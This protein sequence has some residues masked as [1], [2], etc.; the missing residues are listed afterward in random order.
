MIRWLVGSLLLQSVAIADGAF[1]DSMQILLPLDRPHEIILATNFGLVISHDDGTR[2]R[3]ICEEAIGPLA[4]L[5]QVGPPPEDTLLAPAASGLHLSRNDA[6][7][8]SPAQGGLAGAQ[9]IDAFPDATDAKHLFALGILR[10]D[11]G[12]A[13]IRLFESHDAGLTFEAPL[14]SAPVGSFF[15]GVE[16]AR[17]DPKIVYLTRYAFLPTEDPRTYL[18]RSDDSGAHFESFDET[19]AVG[20]RSLRIAAIDPEDAK[21]IYLRVVGPTGQD[22]FALSRDGGKTV[23]ATLTLPGLMSAF[24]RRSDKALLVGSRQGGGFISTD[25]GK[26]FLPW[27]GAPHL[28]ALGERNGL[29]YAAA[30]N[31]A[32]GFSVGVSSDGG[33]HFIPKLR[34]HEIQGPLDCVKNTCAA[35]WQK[36]AALFGIDTGSDAGQS[37]PPSPGCGCSLGQHGRPPLWC[38]LLG[39]LLLI[40]RPISR[41]GCDRQ[42]PRRTALR[43]LTESSPS[44]VAQ[45]ALAHRQ[46]TPR[47][48]LSWSVL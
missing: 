29:V 30:D 31:F 9:V 36:Q 25:G 14:F 44:P 37:I 4:T 22:D 32:D 28:R 6:C 46:P 34:F 7:T 45:A 33:A 26:T 16:S 41:I 42:R 13:P 20:A 43:R 24:L 40:R 35:A 17:T 48:G 5:Y 23:Q 10:S 3:W 21:T 47:G 1:P 11:G 15:G 18:L 38:L 27:M 19:A 8:W 2:W 39:M 12:T